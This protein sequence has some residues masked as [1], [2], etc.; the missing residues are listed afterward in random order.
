MKAALLI[1]HYAMRSG[2]VSPNVGAG[3]LLA[4]D[5]YQS[6][7]RARDHLRLIAQFVDSRSDSPAEVVFLSA[8]ALGD[9]FDRLADDLDGV[10]ESTSRGGSC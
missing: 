7:V 8:Q 9:F 5:G 6:L 1:G 3:Y 4:I 2:S 10:I